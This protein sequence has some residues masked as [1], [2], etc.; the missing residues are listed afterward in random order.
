MDSSLDY[1]RTCGRRLTY[2]IRVND[3]GAYTVSLGD[4]ELLRGHDPLAAGGRHRQPNK[5]KRAGAI[6]QAKRAIES[7]SLM[8]EI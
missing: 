3:N 2:R 6:D 8:E 1:T 4:K 5:R 7:L